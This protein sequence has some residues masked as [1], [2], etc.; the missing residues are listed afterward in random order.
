MKTPIDVA[1]TQLG[2]REATNRNDGIPSKRYQVNPWW[3]KGRPEKHRIR[4]VPWCSL[5]VLYCYRASDWFTIDQREEEWWWMAS[6]L[7]LGRILDKRG[8]RV[9]WQE[10]VHGDI[11]ILRDRGG[12]DVS[13]G[14][15]SG[16]AAMVIDSL[17]READ[18]Y[19]Y[20]STIEGNLGH[21]VRHNVRNL[22]LSTVEGVYRQR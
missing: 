16:H 12:S 15:G 19:P 7:R 9:P 13:T 21:M 3:T 11:I 6:A 20:C 1:I 22:S 4:R 2:V 5:F 18:G 17:G 14:S 8:W 10:A